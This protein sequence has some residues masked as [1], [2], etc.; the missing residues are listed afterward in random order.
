M[1][2]HL[3]REFEYSRDLYVRRSGRL[4]DDERD[5]LP[6]DMG[7]TAQGE[8]RRL[9]VTKLM[10]LGRQAAHA[11][12]HSNPISKVAVAYGLYEAAKLN[13]LEVEVEKV[14]VLVRSALFDI[15]P[16]QDALSAERVEI[17]ME[18]L[19]E[20]VDSH[21]D[22]S[23]NEFHEWFFGPHNS[24][25]KQIAQQK[26]KQ[27]GKLTRE[28]VRRAVL[29]HGVRAFEY[30]GPCVNALMRTIKNSMAPPLNDEEKRLF[31][32]MLES[33][34]Y[35]GNVPAAMLA[36]RMQGLEI[37]VLAIWNEPQNQVHVRVL[38]RLLHYY[39]EMAQ[40][41]RGADSQSKKRR[42]RG[43]QGAP[44]KSRRC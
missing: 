15:E 11:A 25:V 20:A 43:T 4:A 9:T 30:V 1:K 19:L 32:H 33:Q 36:E 12:G 13:P 22:D 16:W 17:V 10:E 38:H 27:G 29:E 2:E 5:V 6:D 26:S 18:R 39:A 23:Q 44:Q 31:E 7:L 34:P 8:G 42:Q 28:I 35:Y 40:K 14:P 21:R 41:R 24:L 37:G 3:T